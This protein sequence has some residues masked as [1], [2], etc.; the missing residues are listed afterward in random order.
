MISLVSMPLGYALA[1]PLAEAIGA[2]STPVA[3]AM[4]CG[5]TNVAMLL[6]PSVP[7]IRR[8]DVGQVVRT[9][10]ARASGVA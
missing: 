1:G 8:P 9:T 2:E 7:N 10:H 6:L 3:A 5:M 4:A